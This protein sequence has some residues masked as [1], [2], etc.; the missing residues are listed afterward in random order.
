MRR[1]V[2]SVEEIRDILTGLAAAG[3]ASGGVQYVRAL[4]CVAMALGVAPEPPKR[5]PD[6]EPPQVVT[7]RSK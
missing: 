5:L 6:T 2:W 1:Q 3:A 4:E 7:E